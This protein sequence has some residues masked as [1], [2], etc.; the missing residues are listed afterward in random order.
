MVVLLVFHRHNV[1]LTFLANTSF[2]RQK[3]VRNAVSKRARNTTSTLLCVVSS[4]A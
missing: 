2:N 3:S 1:Q 4:T